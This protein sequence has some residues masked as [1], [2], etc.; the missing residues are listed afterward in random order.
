MMSENRKRIWAERF[1]YGVGWVIA[2]IFLEGLVLILKLN[3]RLPSVLGKNILVFLVLPIF[4]LGLHFFLVGIWGLYSGYY[5]VPG[6]W[7]YGKER[8]NWAGR[9]N[10]FIS[11]LLGVTIILGAGV[12]VFLYYQPRRLKPGPSRKL[13]TVISP[14]AN[15]GNVF[16]TGEDL[17]TV[18][19]EFRDTAK[20]TL[21]RRVVNFSVGYGQKIPTGKV[22]TA[23]VNSDE[24]IYVAANPDFLSTAE[25]GVA[26]NE[27]KPI[28]GLGS[29]P[30]W[31]QVRSTMQVNQ[32]RHET[33]ESVMGYEMVSGDQ[34][35]ILFIAS[36][37]MDKTAGPPVGQCPCE[38][39]L[40]I[41]LSEPFP[42]SL[43]N[44]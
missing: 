25:V 30:L 31:E 3:F 2:L 36:I 22:V 5:Y 21:P 39:R 17:Q 6:W 43:I 26:S 33:V 40:L 15:S 20:W 34:R 10:G 8:P 28:Q 9:V 41:F 44:F 23:V 18:A 32:R 7:H 24:Y 11:L 12:L 19:S 27:W 13:P 1:G 16:M 42:A 4:L 38:T 29:N 14:T 37:W 35:Q